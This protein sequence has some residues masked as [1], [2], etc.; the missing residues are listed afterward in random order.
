M[1]QS[2]SVLLFGVALQA[3]SML[4]TGHELYADWWLLGFAPVLLIGTLVAALLCGRGRF[5]ALRCVAWAGL[6][7][8][9]GLFV[10]L[11]L[12]PTLATASAC[13]PIYGP[14]CIVV[15]L[16]HAPRVALVSGASFIVP[17]TLGIMILRPENWANTGSYAAFLVAALLASI[18]GGRLA[19]RLARKEE[20]ELAA[21][22]AAVL[23]DRVIAATWEA[24]TESAREMHDYVINTLTALGRGSLSDAP[25][26]RARCASDAE[27]LRTYADESAQNYS[28]GPSL[29]E[30]LKS[31][32][33]QFS[34]AGF[35]VTISMVGDQVEGHPLPPQIVVDKIAAATR[36]ALNNARSY[37]GAGGASI[38]IAYSVGTVSVVIVD[39]GIGIDRASLR[40]GRGIHESI[41]GRLARVGGRTK[42]DTVPAGGTRVCL[43]W[44]E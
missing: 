2:M 21:L 23:A 29:R 22:D 11:A 43:Q 31:L 17:P 7:G 44:P 19:R 14:A 30:Q 15:G 9:C 28:G 24:R 18:L 6:L 3:G 26:W 38:Q 25:A 27:F 12:T 1:Q 39:N 32:A 33:A 34:N 20:E 35:S 4:I 5:S 41:V 37:S 10:T 8:V 16:L 40:P 13:T 36:E 42:I